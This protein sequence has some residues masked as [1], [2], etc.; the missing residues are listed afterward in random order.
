MVDL[1]GVVEAFDNDVQCVGIS[2]ARA[3]CAWFHA[4]SLL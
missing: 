2:L 4:R 1:D 3:S